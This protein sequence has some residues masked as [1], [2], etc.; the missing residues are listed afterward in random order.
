MKR[1]WDHCIIGDW[2]IRLPQLL[3]P[4]GCCRW[5]TWSTRIFL[6]LAAAV[7]FVTIFFLQSLSPQSH[8]H[9]FHSFTLAGWLA[10]L[11]D[12]FPPNEPMLWLSNKY[13]Y[14]C[15]DLQG[16]TGSRPQISSL[17]PNLTPNIN[18]SQTNIITTVQICKAN[19]KSTTYDV[20]R[21][22]F[23][24]SNHCKH[25]CEAVF[26]PL[27]PEFYVMKCLCPDRSHVYRV[28]FRTSNYCKHLCEAV[29]YPRS[30]EFYVIKCLCPD[31]SETL[32]LYRS[33]RHICLQTCLQTGSR[34]TMSTL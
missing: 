3:L 32:Q 8:V 17:T 4:A 13:Y 10:L 22:S 9:M 6:P 29:F 24:T 21:V 25:L 30:P 26:Y 2:I 5:L 18:S 16:R 27:S 28:S 34:P 31:R 15:T 33:A 11:V 19:R 23:R 1:E 20:Y 7:D 14:H 12:D